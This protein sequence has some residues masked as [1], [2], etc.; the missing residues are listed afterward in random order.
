[1][2]LNKITA[3]I[4]LVCS[5]I[6][7]YYSYAA[8]Y[9]LE[10]VAIH[11]SPD[12]CWMIFEEN[13]YD[14]TSYL[15]SH[16][17]FLDIDSWCGLDMTQDF[18]TKAGAG[19]DH[20][21]ST[22]ALLE[23]YKIGDLEEDIILDSPVPTKEIVSMS[24]TVKPTEMTL[25]IDDQAKNPYNLG[26]LVLPTLLL[27]WGWYLLCKR[28]YQCSL[29]KVSVFNFFWNSILLITLIPAVGFGFF[30]V[31]RYSIPSLY[32]VQFDFL[33]WHVEGA[34]IMGTVAVSHFLTRL[35]AYFA[36]MRISLNKQ[37]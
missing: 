2:P 1:M 5:L 4:L 3:F 35:N 14:I 21:S 31:L 25:N 12:D 8:A 9:T 32:G 20:K 26:L 30:M 18:Q 15:R 7:P 29:L 34:I 10:D 22:Y 28:N 13:V 24:D 19:R 37:P 27:Y 36:Q 33:F 6:F 11:N 17:K 16:D 23:Q